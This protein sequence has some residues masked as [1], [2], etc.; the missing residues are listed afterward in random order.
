MS[1]TPDPSKKASEN[2][3][4]LIVA[5]LVFGLVFGGFGLYRYSVGKK[6][7]SWPSVEGKISYARVESTR[8]DGKQKYRP[9]VKYNYVV[10]SKPYTG[11]RVTASDD[12]K[13]NR[14]SA[15][16]VLKNYP[17]GSVV[18]VYYDPADPVTSLLEPG[19]VKNVYL[20][21]L[22]SAVCLFLSSAIAVSAIRKKISG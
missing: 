7:V 18:P 12:L 22:V 3:A 10:N 15:M 13:N 20:V 2:A 5:L 9:A 16:D 21:L 1:E 6:S 19:I 14:G 8:S 11:N 4:I 17:V